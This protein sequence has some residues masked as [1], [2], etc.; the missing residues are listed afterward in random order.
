MYGKKLDKVIN[1]VANATGVKITSSNSSA[2]GWFG[3]DKSRNIIEPSKGVTVEYETKE[4]LE[5]FANLLGVLA[6]DI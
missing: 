6:P 5:A 2:G 3:G 4:Q 1:D